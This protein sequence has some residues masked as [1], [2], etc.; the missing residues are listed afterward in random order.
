MESIIVPKNVWEFDMQIYGH[1]LISFDF[2]YSVGSEEEIDE[3]ENDG[4][5][6]FEYCPKLIRYA[7][8]K[9]RNFALHVFN[10]T[11]AIIGNLVGAKL[12]I[13]PHSIA[14]KIQELAEYY[15]FDSKVAILINSEDE[16]A[17]AIEKKVDVAI[18]PEAI[19]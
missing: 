10:E 8:E 5:L 19:L 6:F 11:E 14:C 9:N 18:L 4:L 3:V 16:I 2:L 7:K 13:C 1:E 15:L 17:L 12:L